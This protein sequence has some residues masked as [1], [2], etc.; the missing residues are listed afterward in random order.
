MTPA[1]IRTLQKLRTGT[2]L[3]DESEE[4][5]ETEGQA[6]EAGPAEAK[7]EDDNPELDQIYDVLEK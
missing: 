2:K 1:S 4:E 5:K 3:D 7:Q 6:K